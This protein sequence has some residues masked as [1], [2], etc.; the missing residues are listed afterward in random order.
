MAPLQLHL[1]PVS[2]P[3]PQ[4]VRGGG[5]GVSPG[6]AEWTQPCLQPILGCGLHFLPYAGG[7]LPSHGEPLVVLSCGHS[8]VLD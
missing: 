5:G 3:S 8:L 7:P 2:V 4:E 6:N 1:S